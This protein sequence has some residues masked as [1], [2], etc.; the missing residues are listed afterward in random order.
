MIFKASHR[1]NSFKVKLINK[2]FV[3][4]VFTE[5]KILAMIAK[6]CN[7]AF[8]NI[9]AAKSVDTG[10]GVEPIAEVRNKHLDRGVAIIGK[11][12]RTVAE[13]HA[14][15]KFYVDFDVFSQLCEPNN[16]TLYLLVFTTVASWFTT[17]VINT[18]SLLGM[19]STLVLVALIAS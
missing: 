1:R 5:D 4:T 11:I 13:I 12:A 3:S 10:L 2:S 17:L 18:S 7:K 19:R 8:C 9:V 16:T 6:F 14:L 15:K